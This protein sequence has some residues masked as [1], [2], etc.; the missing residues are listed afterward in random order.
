MIQLNKVS[1]AFGDLLAVDQFSITIPRG[2]IFGLLGPNGAGKSTL[3]SMISGQLLPTSGSLLI[4]G[5]SPISVAAKR[6]MG[7]APQSLAIYEE[8]SAQANL[9]FFGRLYGLKGGL[10]RSSCEKVLDFVGLSDRATDRVENY[11]GGMKRRLNLAIAL[12]HDPQ[13]LLL[14]EP[15]V[16]VD[17]QSRN[18][19]FDSVLALKEQ[20]KTIVYTT[21]YMEEAEKLCDRVGIVE[22][23]RLLALDSVDKLIRQHGGKSLLSWSSAGSEQSIKTADPL[24]E[25][26]R[27]LAT[28]CDMS[29]L[30][31]ARPDL[32]QVFLNLTGRHLRD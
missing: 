9:E 27:L 24:A 32:E 10:L 1:R 20:G 2:E 23:G 22:Q 4:N 21:H 29:E 15:T 16:G 5:L 25:I 11:S 28:G 31:L 26:Q 18:R 12:L 14:D 6:H 30:S 7:L 3:I 17:P 19:L 8:L 13:V